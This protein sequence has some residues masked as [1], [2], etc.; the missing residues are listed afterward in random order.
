MSNSS[1]EQRT[2]AE[3]IAAIS[4]ASLV[5]INW[6]VRVVTASS[7]AATMNEP[8]L[9]LQLRLLNNNQAENQDQWVT[10]ELNEKEF[11]EFITKLQ[12]TSDIMHKLSIH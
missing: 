3:K 4:P 5:D 9:F 7:K 2:V 6:S 11:D 1:I 8:R 12:H 10:L